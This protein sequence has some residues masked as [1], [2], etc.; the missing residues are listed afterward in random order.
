MHLEEVALPR[1]QIDIETVVAHLVPAAF[2]AVIGQR[3][4]EAP[5]P[6]SQLVPGHLHTSLGGCL[7]II[8]D[9]EGARIVRDPAPGE[10]VLATLVIGPAAAIAEAPL[11]VPEE[12]TVRRVQEAPV[13]SREIVLDRLRRA[14]TQ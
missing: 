6:A 14:A 5:L 2:V 3:I 1:P 7:P 12:I 8:H 11:A 10:D 4:V 13:E 9:D